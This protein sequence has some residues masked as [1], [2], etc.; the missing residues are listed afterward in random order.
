MWIEGLKDV[1]D[2]VSKV[3]KV[4]KESKTIEIQ[5]NN[6]FLNSKS[7]QS[8]LEYLKSKYKDEEITKSLWCTLEEYIK[9][10]RNDSIENRITNYAGIATKTIEAITWQTKPELNELQNTIKKA[11]KDEHISLI[12]NI[13]S[14]GWDE[15]P[16]KNM[17]DE[18]IG[19]SDEEERIWLL[20]THWIPLVSQDVVQQPSTKEETEIQKTP[21][22]NIPYIKNNNINEL[23]P[24]KK[25]KEV[26]WYL[27][28]IWYQHIQ[29]LAIL[30]NIHIESQFNTEAIGD[31]KLKDKAYWICQRRWD[32][33][34]NLK[35]YAIKEWKD[36]KD[37]YLQLDFM[38]QE[39]NGWTE[40]YEEIFLSA[41]TLEKATEV[42]DKWYER[43]NG[44]T[45]KNRINQAL[46]YEKNISSNQSLV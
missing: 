18:F 6:D 28:S 23:S 37:T 21:T 8:L 29:T 39:S 9:K 32:R 34:E 14:I 35:K 31:K 10:T 41:T 33:F 1:M 3:W 12:K 27:R 7:T 40:W 43:S 22:T 11:Q 4:F 2:I 5:E 13:T 15:D 20:Q 36:R 26:Y 46:A 42:F 25:S 17:I 24:E 30:W 16:M 45:I 44:K 38:K 19:L